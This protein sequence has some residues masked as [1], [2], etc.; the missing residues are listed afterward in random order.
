MNVSPDSQRN[1]AD[2]LFARA[3]AGDQAA[4]DELYRT[5]HPKLLR[6]VRRR[7][8]APLRSLYD[9]TDFASDVWRSLVRR[10][11]EFDFPTLGALIAFL[12]KVAQEKV[13]DEYRKRHTLKHD[14]GRQRSLDGIEGD[15]RLD[16]GLASDDP[17]PSQISIAKEGLERLG[18][19][20][21]DPEQRRALELKEQGHSNEEI[22]LLLNWH[23]RKVQRFFQDLGSSW[24]GAGGLP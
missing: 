17:T 23:V 12:S 3:R 18:A 20:L 5:C 6:A 13:I 10:R 19:R 2:A 15:G 8:D 14:I 7:L 16:R 21:T 4:W 24:P 1:D 9:S 22:A 11:D